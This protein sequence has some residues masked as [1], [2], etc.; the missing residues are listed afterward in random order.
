MN[1]NQAVTTFT[2]ILAIT[3]CIM[4][5]FCSH[6]DAHETAFWRH[7]G[8]GEGTGKIYSSACH[9]GWTQVIKISGER[10]NHW[11]RGVM[12][13]RTAGRATLHITENLW[14]PTD[15]TRCDDFNELWY[16]WDESWM[17]EQEGHYD[18]YRR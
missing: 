7:A 3:F 13:Y 16:L 6:A 11:W 2:L 8:V 9:R 17:K 15:K 18:K 14:L 4:I 1:G 12:F 5:G 10:D